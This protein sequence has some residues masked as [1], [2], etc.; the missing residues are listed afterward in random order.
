MSAVAIDLGGTKIAAA[1]VDDS[2]RIVARA[3]CAT[4]A[5]EGAAQVLDAVAA[6]VRDVHDASVRGIGVGSLGVIDP[7]RG[8]VMA[9]LET[10]RGWTGTD[11]AGG[12][13]QRLHGMRVRVVND[14]HAHALGEAWQGAAQGLDS[15]LV[16]AIGTGIGGCWLREGKPHVGAHCVAGHFGE[17]QVP[18]NLGGDARLE[19]L[20]A[21][22]AILRHY[23]RLGGNAD[24][25]DTRAVFAAYGEDTVATR[26]LD[27]AAH[28]IGVALAGL[29]NALD[30]ERIV[31]GGGLAEVPAWWWDEVRASYRSA[32]LPPLRELDIIKAAL[33]TDAA[34]IGAA[35]LIIQESLLT[36]EI[37]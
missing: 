29:A 27:N 12:L 30:P 36:K 34:L 17:M 25:A 23:Q 11:I 21:G 31:Y 35:S 7:A 14:V 19:A 18:H 3:Q 33:G 22:P 32:V 26:V 37:P 4:P 9:A 2:G 24:I 6:L 16:I 28:G 1:R 5:Q 13:Q 20:A 15:V 8:V 10:L